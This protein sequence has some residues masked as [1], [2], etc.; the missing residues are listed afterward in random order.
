MPA[1]ATDTHVHLPADT[2]QALG[3]ADYAIK[4]IWGG[5]GERLEPDASVVERINQFHT[6]AV[7]CGLSALALGC[8][9]PNVLRDEAFQ[10]AVPEGN[11]GKGLGKSKH[12]GATTFGSI[13]NGKVMRVKSEK[14]IVANCSAVREWD[15]NGTNFGFNPELGHIAGEFGHNDFYAVA[16]AAAQMLGA[17][18][19]LALRGM[20]A[21]DEIRGR[22]AEVFSLKS[23][24]IDHV[25][26]GAIASAAVFG[27]MVGATREQIESAIGMS[28]AHYIPFR[29]IRAGKQ[30]SDSKGASAA[31]STEA[32]ILSVKR[33]MAGFLGPRDIFRNPEAIFRMFEGPGQMAQ[34]VDK[35]GNAIKPANS[36]QKDASPF[37]L[38]LGRAGSDF[39]VMGMHFKLGLYEHQSAGALQAMITLLNQAPKLLEKK[40]GG[41]IGNIKIVAYEP[42][43][44]IIGDPAKRNPTTRQSADHSM[45]YIV[46]TL[47]RKA[48]EQGKAGWTDLMLEPKDY[49][50]EAINN[51]LTRTLM[52]K[53]EFAHGGKEYDDRYP[54]GI[55]TS[56][57]ITDAD[58]ASH[59]SGLVMYPGGHARNA[60]GKTPVDLNVVLD[61]KFTLLGSL[62]F[63]NPTPIINKY[64][65][66]HTK[67]ADDV[68]T[69]NDYELS[70]SP[71]RFD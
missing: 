39:A 1:A 25:V 15:S 31:I 61:H 41:N 62:A 28:V 23:Y 20:L 17:D 3:I 19:E 10:Y 43:F 13:V 4:A 42:A 36:A 44:G 2:N 67:S 33:S 21:I 24:K 48:L 26:H 5:P 27:A 40:D 16:L 47:L 6:D 69:I 60:K 57:V 22:L 18:G 30:L 68:Q 29:A 8:N 64:R 59:D 63:A 49:G 14:A 58:G 71:T 7:I 51:S 56:V 54:D 46:S 70:I 37:D 9:A 53:I 32:A 50:P 12:H 66:L 34:M 55:P 38:V 65:D 35:N 11:L 52:D 45:V